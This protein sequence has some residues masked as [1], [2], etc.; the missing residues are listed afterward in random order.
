MEDG[1]GRVEV[2]IEPEQP[3]RTQLQDS[4]EKK[5]KKNDD[6]DVLERRSGDGET[7]KQ[8]LDVEMDCIWEWK[9]F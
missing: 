5:K 8:S 9:F 6:D 7:W 3:V 4:S 1:L 2:E